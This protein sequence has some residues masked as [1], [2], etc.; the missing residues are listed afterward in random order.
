MNKL[1]KEL[2]QIVD[3]NPEVQMQKRTLWMLAAEKRNEFIEGLCKEGLK[4][5]EYSKEVIKFDK[6]NQVVFY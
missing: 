2:L 6:L 3:G 5:K 4:G 1:N